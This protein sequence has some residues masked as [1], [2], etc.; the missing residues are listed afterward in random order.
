[1]AAGDPVGARPAA[2][3]V[4]LLEPL[5][6]ARR[7]SPLH[8]RNAIAPDRAPTRTSP[9]PG[10]RAPLRSAYARSSYASVTALWRICADALR[11]REPGWPPSGRGSPRGG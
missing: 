1:G 11:R 2:D 4:Q 8:R 5:E 6:H 3:R 9:P 7:R 10:E